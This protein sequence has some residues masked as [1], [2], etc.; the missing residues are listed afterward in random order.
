M[1]DTV[2]YCVLDLGTRTV[3][4]VDI[5]RH[6]LL[7]GNASMALGV[8]MPT[9]SHVNEAAHENEIKI[10]KQNIVVSRRWRRSVNT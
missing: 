10:S 8:K 1:L 2:S 4:E 7:L 6:P 3:I 5:N 9:L